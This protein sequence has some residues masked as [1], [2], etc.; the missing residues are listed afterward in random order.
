MRAVASSRCSATITS[1]TVTNVTAGGAPVYNFKFTNSTVTGTI[2]DAYLSAIVW[3]DA[4]ANAYGYSYRV[5]DTAEGALGTV[6]FTT[7]EEAFEKAGSNKVYRITVVDGVVNAEVATKDCN[8]VGTTKTP[9][10]AVPATCTTTGL[11]AGEV[12]ECG[13]TT[14]EQT[15]VSALGHLYTVGKTTCGRDNCDV[16][17]VAA[18]GDIGYPTLAD[19]LAAVPE[20]GSAP[21][22]ITLIV[23]AN[24]D[25][26][27]A[28]TNKKVT[29]KGAT[30]NKGVALTLTGV[31][32]G[33]YNIKTNA[34][35]NFDNLK[36]VLS[37][38]SSN[39]VFVLY[40]KGINIS[41]NDC[42]WFTTF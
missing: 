15:V 1:T 11:T 24:W 6:Y 33:V 9:I 27:K 31:A 19:A 37:A 21:T 40:G 28:F 42:C 41:F 20:N 22:E 10:P 13:T 16:A 39:N 26:T 32:D 30:A 35:L 36:I 3:D 18:I 12:C 23:N 2:G 4:S 38:G 25:S 29:L 14:V 34:T 8:H 5:G 7:K 17:L